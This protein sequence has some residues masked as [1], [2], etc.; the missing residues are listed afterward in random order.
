MTT[1][2][3][4]EDSKQIGPYMQND[5]HS[6]AFY[7][8]CMDLIRVGINDSPRHPY[9][10]NDG[11]PY[12]EEYEKCAFESIDQLLD[13]FNGFE[14]VLHKDGFFP[15]RIEVPD[16]AV[17]KGWHQVIFEDRDSDRTILSWEE[18]I[19]PTRK[20][21]WADTVG[22]SNQKEGWK[23]VQEAPRGSRSTASK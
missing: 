6:G 10:E 23:W 18:V 9:P 20:V 8:R 15:V 4:V 11:L 2:Y 12:P 14:D 1:L 16:F 3:R 19:D 21:W 22:S 13:W 7:E 5:R 17:K